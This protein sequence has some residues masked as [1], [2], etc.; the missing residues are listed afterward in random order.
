MHDGPL[1]ASVAALLGDPARANMMT[2]LMDGRALTASELAEAA[3]VTLQT[4]SGHLSKLIEAN[5][6]KAEKQGRHRYFRLSDADVALVMERLMALAQRT[7]AVR[8]RP[9]PRDTALRF[10]RIC[11]DHLAGELAVDLTATL[12][13]RRIIAGDTDPRLTAKGRGFFSEIGI[14][15][16]PLEQGRRRICR[17]CLDWSERKV[18]LSGALGAAIL[19][20]V[21]DRRWAHLGAGR[22]VQF[23]KPGLQSFGIV[24]K[25]SPRSRRH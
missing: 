13:Q 17:T 11:Y 12:F 19:R 6:L 1:I 4:T 21:L 9:G 7:G 20:D 16:G 2:A 15:T 5:L 24:F 14:D 8:I 10:A 18:H 23:T 3:G 25:R 22:V